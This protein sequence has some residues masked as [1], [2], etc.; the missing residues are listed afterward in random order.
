MNLFLFKPSQPLTS[1]LI[2]FAL[3]PLIIIAMSDSIDSDSS[4]SS[5]P[6][7]HIIYTEKP[8]EEEPEAYHIRTLTAV[9]GSEEAAKDALLYS[10]KNAASGFSAKL[11]PEQVAQ[12]SKQPGVLQ[13]V[14]S[15]TYQL[16]SGPNKLH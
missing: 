4:S 11:T 9:F 12:I 3:L 10:Y 5:A 2:I 6:A 16:H 7:V 1:F 13:V 8:Q 15:Q 14:P